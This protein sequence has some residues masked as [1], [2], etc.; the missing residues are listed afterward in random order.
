MF[1]R[2]GVKILSLRK[3]IIE[4]C[5]SL[6]I[7]DLKLEGLKLSLR[8]ILN[9]ESSFDSMKNIRTR[10]LAWYRVY[11]LTRLP[12]DDNFVCTAKFVIAKSS[13]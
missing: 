7:C 1:E 2:F 5:F 9:V 3:L 11:S 10:R 12:K 4:V 8:F 13:S 6:L